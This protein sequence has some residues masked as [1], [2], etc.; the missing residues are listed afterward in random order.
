MPVITDPQHALGLTRIFARICLQVVD[1]RA[2]GKGMRDSELFG[3]LAH[4]LAAVQIAHPGPHY[5]MRRWSLQT[6]DVQFL[7]LEN[8]SV[9]IPGASDH[10]APPHCHAERIEASAAISKLP[11]R[12]DPSDG[13]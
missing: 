4:G 10:P 11:H 2:W 1:R 7:A 8:V 9:V 13:A 6:M 12:V 3:A 5:G